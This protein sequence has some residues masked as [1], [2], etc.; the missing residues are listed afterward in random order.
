M[1][2]VRS[3]AKKSPFLL[4]LWRWFDADASADHIVH[5]DAKKVDWFRILPFVI[6]HL[7]C[8]GVI[9]VGWSRFAVVTAV[10]L[11]FIRMFAI[12]GFYHRYFSHKSFQTNRFWQ[13][14]FAVL[15]NASVQRG[16][17]WWAAHHRHHHRYADTEKDIHS[18]SRH[19]F[20]WSHVGWLTSPANFPTKMQYVKDWARFPELRWINRFDTVVPVLLAVALFVGGNLLAIHAPQLGTNGPQLLIW[21]FFISSV[22]LFHGTVTIN[23]LD[24]MFGSRRYD[25]PDTSRNNAL[26]ALITLGEGW[27]NN[28]HHYAV[29]ARQGFFWWEIDITYYLLKIFS[30]LGIVWNLRGL[31]EGLRSQNR[32][33]CGTP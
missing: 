21:G 31:P 16:P 6:M 28:H 32:K 17:L 15:G 3:G 2:T 30:W 33:T 27:H 9:W 29:S 24:H 26:L 22:A 4:S 12:T 20:I 8:L 25:T 7:M 13:F 1:K 14:C 19:G 5:L 11:Y 10:V 18:P 23:S